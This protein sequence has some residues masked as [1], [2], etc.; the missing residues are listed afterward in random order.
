MQLIANAMDAKLFAIS[1]AFSILQVMAHK[2]KLSHQ[3][4]AFWIFGSY[5]IDNLQCWKLSGRMCGRHASLRYA[6]LGVG[7]WVMRNW[8]TDRIALNKNWNSS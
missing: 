1:G 8:L 5:V 7:V 3:A 6:V 2:A 4:V